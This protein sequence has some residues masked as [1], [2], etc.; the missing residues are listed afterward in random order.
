MC[1]K[2]TKI[3]VKAPFLFAHFPQQGEKTKKMLLLKY[4]DDLRVMA[5]FFLLPPKRYDIRKKNSTF[6]TSNNIGI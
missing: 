2:N 3:A 1:Y 6:A 4:R 5:S